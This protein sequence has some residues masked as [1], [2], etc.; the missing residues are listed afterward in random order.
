VSSREP[1]CWCALCNHERALQHRDPNQWLCTAIDPNGVP[2]AYGGGDTL[3]K[4]CES[5]REGAERFIGDI[6][7]LGRFKGWKWPECPPDGW[8]PPDWGAILKR[9][10]D[11]HEVY[12]D[13]R[14]R[15]DGIFADCLDG[16]TATEL[17]ALPDGLLVMWGDIFYTNTRCLEDSAWRKIADWNAADV[18]HWSKRGD[19]AALADYIERGEEITPEIESFIVAILRGAKKPSKPA[20]QSKLKR[21]F[22][23]IKYILAQRASRASKAAAVE[24]ATRTWTH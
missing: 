14:E 18:M 12:R 13:I 2:R 20:T 4:A 24:N 9:S 21:D 22:E 3:A 17:K 11:G 1:T 19:W 7:K 5:A 8:E 15:Y 6:K 23:I 10:E 16:I